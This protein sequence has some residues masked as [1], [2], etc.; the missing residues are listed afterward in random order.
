MDYDLAIVIRRLKRDAIFAFRHRTTLEADHKDKYDMLDRVRDVRYIKSL[1]K[2]IEV[3][4]SAHAKTQQITSVEQ[5]ETGVIY[6]IQE[7]P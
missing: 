4:R 1:I 7:I 5:T 3:L 2:A 6:H